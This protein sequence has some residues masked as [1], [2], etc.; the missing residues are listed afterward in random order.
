MNIY[1]GE[2][3]NIIMVEDFKNSCML[4]F[5]F[6][7]IDASILESTDLSGLE[8]EAPLTAVALLSAGTTMSSVNSKQH[9]APQQHSL[10]HT[11]KVAKRCLSRFASLAFT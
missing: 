3:D 8:E 11:C 4:L 7:I 2:G 9:C 5:H 6:Q 10:T 1:D